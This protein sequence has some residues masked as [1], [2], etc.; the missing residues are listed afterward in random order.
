MIKT[1]LK[2]GEQKEQVFIMRRKKHN[3]K[4]D[5]KKPLK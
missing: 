4:N 3:G 2:M 1:S 5:P